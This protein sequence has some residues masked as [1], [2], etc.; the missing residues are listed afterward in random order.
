[1]SDLIPAMLSNGEYVIRA[2]AVNE[3]GAGF[4]DSLNRGVNP[5]REMEAPGPSRGDAPSGG[6]VINGGITVNSVANEGVEESLPR[7]LRRMAFLAG[8]NG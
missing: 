1:M 7:A 2:Q 5:L 6:F 8:V 4:F 3:F